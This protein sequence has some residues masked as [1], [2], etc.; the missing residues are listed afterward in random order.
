[1]SAESLLI[2]FDKIADAPQAIPCLRR[3]ILD[4]AVRGKLVDQD[5]KDEPS[6]GVVEEDCRGEGAT[7]QDENNQGT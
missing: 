2:H 5:P 4:L 6:V 1:M 7:G 3:F